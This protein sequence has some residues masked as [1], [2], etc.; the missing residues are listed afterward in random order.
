ML[1]AGKADAFASDDILLAGF[2]ATR[3]DGKRF[4]ITGDYL[5]YEPYAIG[6]R[7]DDPA[8]AG[9]VRDSFARMATE[10]TL[11]RR[12]TR[13]LMDRLPTGE[14]LN[15]PISPALAEMYRAMGQPD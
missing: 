2:I 13:W 5:S 1:A 3:P 12:Y 4:G 9:L 14:R 7:R 6:F 10:G 11:N 8:F 15:V